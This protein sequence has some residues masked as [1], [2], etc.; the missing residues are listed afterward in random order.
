MEP[1]ETVAN[2]VCLFR[3]SRRDG[4]PCFLSGQVTDNN[5]SAHP[6]KHEVESGWLPLSQAWVCVSALSQQEKKYKKYPHQLGAPKEADTM[7]NPH[8]TLTN[9][10]CNLLTTTTKAVFWKTCCILCRWTSISTPGIMTDWQRDLLTPR[11]KLGEEYCWMPGCFVDSNGARFWQ[12]S[13]QT[14]CVKKV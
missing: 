3:L 4:I 11:P 13:K 14:F 7:G 6:C 5:L 12:G 2:T 1:L 9:L 10:T 8:M